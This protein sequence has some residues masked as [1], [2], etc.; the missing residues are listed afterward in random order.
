MELRC[1]WDLVYDERF[2]RT[3]ELLMCNID[4][5][6]KYMGVVKYIKRRDEWI[7]VWIVDVGTLV[8]RLRSSLLECGAYEA[9]RKRK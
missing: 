5:V 9:S 2:K 7:D 1:T 4:G 6:W 3:T 8:Y